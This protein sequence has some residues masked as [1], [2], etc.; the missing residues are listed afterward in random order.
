MIKLLSLVLTLTVLTGA[1][2]PLLGR[3]PNISV[4]NPFD[5][6]QYVGT[7]YEAEKYFA[8]FELGG[9][10]ITATY[11]PIASGGVKVFN[12]QLNIK[13][14]QV[15]TIEGTATLAGAANEG[16]LSVVFPS[17]PFGR[18][19]PYW[20]LDTDYTNYAVVY[21]CTDFFIFHTD[22]VWILTRAQNPPATVMG[23]AYSVMDRYGL[24]RALLIPT[25]QK[26][27]PN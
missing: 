6:S 27:C 5:V 14:N 11:T 18:A 1:Q 8:I 24:N 21:S 22:I 3:C 12:R 10:C 7:W 16:K 13:T 17:I 2:V 26:S 19:A 15:R 25:D 23:A 9:K 4:K 20:V